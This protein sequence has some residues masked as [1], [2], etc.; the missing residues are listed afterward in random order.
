MAIALIFF[1]SASLTSQLLISLYSLAHTPSPL[2]NRSSQY[3]YVRESSCVLINSRTSKTKNKPQLPATA[4]MPKRQHRG[5][6]RQALCLYSSG[7][8]FDLL[9]DNC[10]LGMEVHETLTH[11]VSFYEIFRSDSAVFSDRKMPGGTVQIAVVSTQKK[12]C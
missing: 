9:R 1:L 11:A 10:D 7:L 12:Y 4:K 3:Q 2:H 6:A 8:V 5:K